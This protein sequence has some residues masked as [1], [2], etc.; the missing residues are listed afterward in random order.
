M[1]SLFRTINKRTGKPHPVWRFKYL[2]ATGRR[3]TGTGWP[4]KK[5][6]QE[7]ALS[8][9]AEC[10]AIRT[11]QKQAPPSWL[12][13]RSKPVCDI[14]TEYLA[15]G[16]AQG[17]RGGRPWD[18]QNA[19]DKK[20]YLE[21]W[22]KELPLAV[23]AD[24]NLP[25]VERLSRGLLETLSPKSVSLRLE[26]LKSLVLWSVKRGYIGEDP[27]RG[28]TAIDDRPETPHRALTEEEV[29]ALL[30]KC[31]PAHRLWY[32]V[33]LATGYRVGELRALKVRDLDIFGPSLPLGAD[34]TKNR[35]DAR[36]PIT[37]ALAEKLR[38]LCQGRP[39]EDAMLG[40]QSSHG[41][42]QIAADYALAGVA[43]LA[44]EGKATWHSLRK[45]FV[46]N[47]CRGG[48]DVK[49]VME[50]ARHSSATM[51]MDVY[52]SAK[53]ALLRSAAEK[54]AEQ[55]DE[56]VRRAGCPT[57]VQRVAAGNESAS[58]NSNAEAALDVPVK[59]ARDWGRTYFAKSYADLQR[60]VI[61][62][63]MERS[64]AYPTGYDGSTPQTGSVAERFVGILEYPEC[65]TGVQRMAHA[66]V[67]M[68]GLELLDLHAR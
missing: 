37:R 5:K 25:A 57:D 24:V 45:T 26:A 32:E 27:L 38:R 64:G 54:A 40:I 23:L 9:E 35:K 16:N 6:T 18:K 58:A 48:A 17:G 66:A 56:A 36:Q 47:V 13:H 12:K 52:A 61:G 1:A 53:P 55:I 8:L 14:I 3:R 51:S 19:R 62:A 65:P 42:K 7:H 4:D 29:G 20:K 68:A 43:P 59:D 31:D 60:E 67:M 33:A 63:T 28:M 11:G 44:A 34:F 2:D 21:W 46:N 41:Y 22:A 10:R 30:T 39:D 49:T 15:W 50:L